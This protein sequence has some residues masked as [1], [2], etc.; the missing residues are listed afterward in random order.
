[1]DGHRH[2]IIDHWLQPIRDVADAHGDSLTD[3]LDPDTRLNRLC[4]L[5][6]AAQVAGLSRT[7]IIQSAW[8]RGKELAIH[9]WVYGLNDGL[10]RDLDCGCAGNR[11]HRHDGS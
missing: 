11:P 8:K 5:S 2:G 6:I 1:M 7:P 3:L 10:I 9:G 4:K